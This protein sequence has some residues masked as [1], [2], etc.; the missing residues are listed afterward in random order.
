M[1]AHVCVRV[2]ASGDAKASIRD[3][4]GLASWL[5][6]NRESRPGNAL[7]VDGTC[8]DADLGSISRAHASEIE[9]LLR[10]EMASRPAGPS[11]RKSAGRY[12]DDHPR[13]GFILR[14]GIPVSSKCRTG[15]LEEGRHLT[16]DVLFMVP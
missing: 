1:S 11:V 7:F 10:K 3:A 9:I 14:P 12:P 4:E 2:Y 6:F 15:L 8:A 16:D 5:S 13:D